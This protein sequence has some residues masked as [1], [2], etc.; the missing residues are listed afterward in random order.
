M[1]RSSEMLRFPGLPC[2]LEI[3]LALCNNNLAHDTID[4]YRN[5][6]R[7]WAQ[8]TKCSCGLVAIHEVMASPDLC[9]RGPGLWPYMNI[10]RSFRAP[11]G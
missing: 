9:S 8:L 6:K 11:M 7:A 2:D 10:V 1:Q 4:R 3:S 5:E